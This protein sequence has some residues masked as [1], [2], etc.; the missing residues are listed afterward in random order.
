MAYQRSCGNHNMDG[1]LATRLLLTSSS[2]CRAIPPLGDAV[3]DTADGDFNKRVIGV[4]SPIEVMYSL[5]LS[6]RCDP[7]SIRTLISISVA[8]TLMTL[9]NGIG[10]RGRYS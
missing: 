10:L 5:R 3:V 8:T 6:D 1:T 4:K 9:S 7:Q 2:N